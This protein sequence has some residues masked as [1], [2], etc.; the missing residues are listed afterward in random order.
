MNLNN[1][2]IAIDPNSP[3]LPASCS[4]AEPLMW[5]PEAA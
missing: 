3:P 1:F 4:P 5:E 2:V